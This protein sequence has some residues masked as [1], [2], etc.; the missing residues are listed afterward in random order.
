MFKEYKNINAVILTGGKSS[1]IGVNKSLLKLDDQTLLERSISLLF[2]IFNEVILSVNN[3]DA[4]AEYN[5]KKAVDIHKEAGPLVGIY[6]SL[7][8]SKTDLNFVLSCDMPFVTNDLIRFL[9]EFPSEKQ[10]KIPLEGGKMHPL[11]GLYSKKILPS[12]E[13]FIND[14]FTGNELSSGKNKSLSMK[15]FLET[16]AVE[17]I[18]V[19]KELAAYNSDMFFNI[20]TIDDFNKANEIFHQKKL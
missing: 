15:Q 13:K 20:N 2:S 17:Y 7:M 11:C 3:R 18:D 14:A 4:Y 9:I 12:L 10:I 6:S 1:R 19:E 8:T 5:L 16:A